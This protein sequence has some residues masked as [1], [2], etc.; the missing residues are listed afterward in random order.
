MTEDAKA[1]QN[2]SVFRQR[3]GVA[4]PEAACACATAL[5]LAMSV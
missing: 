5:V 2:R 4:D 1:K 3:P